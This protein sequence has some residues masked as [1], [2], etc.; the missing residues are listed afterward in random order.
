MN[1]NYFTINF[2]LS[3]KE[4]L[5][6]ID[7]NTLGIVFTVDK[8]KVIGCV[9]DGDIRSSLLNGYSL[10]DEISICMNKSFIYANDN[11][12]REDIN[13]LFDSSIKVIP[14]LSKSGQLLKIL[15][16][17][18]FPLENESQVIARSKSPV[19]V[20]FVEGDLI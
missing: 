7:K 13:K 1:S 11:F 19:R 6:K 2:K 16:A 8:N 20:S 10:D 4:A 14:F 18:D 15:T 12:S 5:L 3:I 9:T 17:T